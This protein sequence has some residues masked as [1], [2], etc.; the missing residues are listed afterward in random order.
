M[1][2][3]AEKPSEQIKTSEGETVQ[4]QICL[5]ALDFASTVVFHTVQVFKLHRAR[6]W[7][8]PSKVSGLYFP[9]P[10][11]YKPYRL[12]QSSGHPFFWHPYM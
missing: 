11:A 7:Q 1:C 6:S 2:A 3:G 4:P 9:V 5:L 10:D 8:L 12:S